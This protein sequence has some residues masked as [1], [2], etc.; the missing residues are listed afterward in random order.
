MALVVAFALFAVTQLTRTTLAV[1][2]I[3]TRV[4]DIVGSVDAVD[5]GTAPVAVLDETGRLTERI[6]GAAQPLSGQA[7]EIVASAQSIDGHVKEILTSATTINTSARQ[8]NATVRGI[9]ANA[10][11]I[12][13][14]FAKLA[15][16]VVSIN[17]GVAGINHRGDTV[18]T[19]SQGIKSDT[20][21]IL[22]NA[23]GV[24]LH[25]RSIDCSALI[26]GRSC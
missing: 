6:L 21:N 23:K 14:S 15:P 16:V 4:K 25:A 26:R 13:G 10:T 3:D 8:I 24:D 9:N 7:G 18:I 19:L 12:L 22:A 11:G 5:T 17:N 2:Q 1:Q 20:G